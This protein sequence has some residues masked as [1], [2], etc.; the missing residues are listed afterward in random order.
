[1]NRLFLY[2]TLL[3]LAV[4][5]ALSATSLHAQSVSDSGLSLSQSE[6]LYTPTK[7]YTRLHSV[8]AFARQKENM[9][10]SRIMGAFDN[11]YKESLMLRGYN[12]PALSA[13]LAS[14]NHFSYRVGFFGDVFSNGL[15]FDDNTSQSA[16]ATTT[17]APAS[18][19][20]ATDSRFLNTAATAANMLVKYTHIA[21]S[22]AGQSSPVGLKFGVAY[23]F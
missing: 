11:V 12:R 2:R 9:L 18:L 15:S 8:I 6:F 17:T 20:T 16:T 23:N 7:Q 4:G 14:A 5:L 22:F 3:L 13:T 1:M 10:I 19:N 21:S